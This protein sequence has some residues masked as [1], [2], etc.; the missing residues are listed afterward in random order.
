M[1]AES[2]TC[3]R[4][5]NPKTF[6]LQ[7]N[8]DFAIPCVYN[9]GLRSNQHENGQAIV[10]WIANWYIFATIPYNMPFFKE[11]SEDRELCPIMLTVAT[12]FRPWCFNKDDYFSTKVCD[13][14]L[15]A[16]WQ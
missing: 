4:Q 16:L 5:D 14:G 2:F 13:F 9:V 3:H 8:I 15:Y 12:P 6:F 1:V 11:A 10:R 7:L